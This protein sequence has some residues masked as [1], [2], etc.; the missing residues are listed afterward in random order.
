MLKDGRGCLLSNTAPKQRISG[1]MVMMTLTRLF[2]SGTIRSALMP[3]HSTHQAMI[4]GAGREGGGLTLR[5]QFP[6]LS[7][8]DGGVRCRLMA[9]SMTGADH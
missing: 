6:L 2:G 7:S 1:K 3:W 8:K 5:R 9:M 4:Q